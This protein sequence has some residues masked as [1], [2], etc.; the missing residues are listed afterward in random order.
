MRRATCALQEDKSRT[1]VQNRGT[2]GEN[3]IQPMRPVRPQ[4]HRLRTDASA[5][6]YMSSV[7]PG[8]WSRHRPLMD[9]PRHPLHRRSAA[10]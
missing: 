3:H 1:S 9:L 5:S 10:G 2:A 6:A 8:S 4:E 7:Q